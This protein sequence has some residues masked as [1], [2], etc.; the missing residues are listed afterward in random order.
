[1][2]SDPVLQAVTLNWVP[3]PISSTLVN[4]REGRDDSPSEIQLLGKFGR[5]RY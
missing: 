5:R 1:M 3:V 4:L 2:Q